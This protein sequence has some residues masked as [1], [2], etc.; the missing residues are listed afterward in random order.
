[1]EEIKSMLNAILES[2]QAMNA[3]LKQITERLDRMEGRMKVMEE[4]LE[5]TDKAITYLAGDV[6][7]LKIKAPSK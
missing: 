5:R 3:Q 1:M 6:Y 4:S 7:R 2:Q